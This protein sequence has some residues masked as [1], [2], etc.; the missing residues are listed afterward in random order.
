M[1]HP[2]QN[3]D[4]EETTQVCMGT[5]SVYHH[6]CRVYHL[7]VWLNDLSVVWEA[8]PT[9]CWVHQSYR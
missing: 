2:S 9:P 6:S 3:T 8:A 1:T 5:S 4:S 7:K